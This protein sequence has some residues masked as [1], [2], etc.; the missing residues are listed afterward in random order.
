MSVMVGWVKERNLGVDQNA[1]ALEE[2]SKC[3]DYG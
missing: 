3:F 1:E 2:Q